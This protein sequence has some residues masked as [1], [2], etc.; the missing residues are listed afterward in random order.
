MA[1]HADIYAKI[2]T[3]LTDALALTDHQSCKRIDLIYAPAAAYR[4]DQIKTWT[5]EHNPEPFIGVEGKRSHVYTEAL[6]AEILELAESHADSYGQGRHRFSLRTHQHLGNRQTHSF[7]ILPSVDSDEGALVGSGGSEL[8]P[9]QAGITTQLMRHLENRDRQAQT[10]MA[11]YIGGMSSMQ[12][13]LRDENESLRVQLAAKDRER[14]EWLKT[15]EE[16]RSTEHDRQIE[17]Q[18]VVAKEERKTFATK[19]AMSLLPVALSKFMGSGKP[20]GG[21]NA[22]KT[23]PSPLAILVA[24]L[25][26]SLTDDQRS[27]L[28][29]FLAM[30]QG[31]ALTE[32]VTVVENGDSALLPAMLNDLAS[33]LSGRQVQ[34]VM[35]IFTGEQ[36]E[37][38]VKAIKLA[39]VQAEPKPED[40]SENGQAKPEASA[41]AQ[42]LAINGTDV[43]EAHETEAQ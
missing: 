29:G 36:R 26:E 19:K 20:A 10:M 16:A 42:T 25:I 1:D 12:Q 14:M 21:P 15:I 18:Q 22:K 37:L 3:F 23:P 27:Q 2:C 30:E 5:R 33:G 43:A 13:Q 39:Q 4:T 17:A 8:V 31:I 32:I 40:K 6:C 38:F 7:V 24:K 11:A 34:A 28:G 41:G 35:G 9:T